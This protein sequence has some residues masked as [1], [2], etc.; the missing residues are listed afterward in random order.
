MP[1]NTD[2]KMGPLYWLLQQAWTSHRDIKN[3]DILPGPLK[4]GIK[5]IRFTNRIW[6]QR[7]PYIVMIEFKEPIY[8]FMIETATR[9]LG[10]TPKSY[11][12]PDLEPSIVIEIEESLPGGHTHIYSGGSIKILVCGTPP[13][14]ADT[15]SKRHYFFQT[16]F[17]RPQPE[18][19]VIQ[20][21]LM[22]TYGNS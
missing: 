15:R 10:Y 21:Y 16:S 13:E 22:Q 20:E 9:K 19:E 17:D 8:D 14:L 5:Q 11:T 6:R 4:K 2:W 12:G 3:K 18:V 7:G 1:T